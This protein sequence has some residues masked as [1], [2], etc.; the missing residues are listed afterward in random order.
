M[1]VYSTEFFC[2]CPN[3]DVRIKF[4]L[5]IETRNTLAVESILDGIEID[6][7]E[8][9]FHEEL[10][11]ILLARFEGL[12]VLTAEHHGVTIQTTRATS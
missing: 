10:A 1:N 12:Q 9:R 5:R 2:R 8:P 6:T 3:N 7:E 11:D 4:T